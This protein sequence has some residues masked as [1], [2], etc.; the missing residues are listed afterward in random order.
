MID[1][2]SLNRQSFVMVYVCELTN[3]PFLFT[4]TK[5]KDVISK[6]Q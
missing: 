6:A 1:R 5:A 2:V 4:L 3:L